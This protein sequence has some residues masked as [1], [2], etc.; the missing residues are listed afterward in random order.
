MP[1]DARHLVRLTAGWALLADFIPL[2]AVY[3]LLFADHG[4]SDAQISALFALWSV[5][6][7]LAEIPSGAVADRF[8]RRS[9]LVTS[10][11]FQAA[12]YLTWLA[13]PSF[14]GFAAG[15]VLWAIGGSFVSGALEA[16]VYDGLAAD[17]VA[18]RYAEV[19]GRISALGLLTQVAA[20]ALAAP[21]FVVGEYRLVGGVSV[22]ACLASSLVAAR[23]PEP[24]RA[25]GGDDEDDRGYL[26]LLRTGIKDAASTPAM[27]TAIVAVGLLSG[28]DAF[29]EYVPLLARNWGVPTGATPLATI[30]IPV[31]AALGAAYAGRADRLRPPVLGAML[32]A[33]GFLLVAAAIAARPAGL[34]GVT[35]FYG[36]YR[37][38]WVV[39]GARLQQEIESTARATV[40]SVAGFGTELAA[41]L[42]FAA[43]AIGGLPLT[44]AGVLL[45][46]AALPRWLKM[47]GRR[48][49]REG[50]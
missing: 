37:V 33:G 20:T 7:V 21:L 1:P 42:L 34:I 30:G 36:L 32:G 18:D 14:A 23:L 43:W 44:A 45:L 49:A 5:V 38:V 12:G 3:A 50:A 9:S 25:G 31:V 48:D 16:L 47:A 6:G 46:A 39:A 40:T 15:F 28:V 24:L 13:Q 17:G 10:G 35:L 26:T 11:V 2:Y 29:E 8:T 27:R 22:A 4:M 41:L 19:Y